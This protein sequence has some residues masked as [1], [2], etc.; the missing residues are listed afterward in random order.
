[1]PPHNEAGNH[2]HPNTQQTSQGVSGRERRILCGELFVNVCLV[3]PCFPWVYYTPFRTVCQEEKGK[4]NA[5]FC[6]VFHRLFHR[7]F[8]F[9]GVRVFSHGAGNF[10]GFFGSVRA[11]FR[12][13]AVFRIFFRPFF[14]SPVGCVVFV[15]AQ[16]P[17]CSD[18]CRRSVTPK[19]RRTSSL[20]RS[21]AASASAVAS[22]AP[23]KRI[24]QA[25]QQ[26]ASR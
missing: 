16:T 3:A 20:N 18:P 26:S 1:M 6:E 12:R 14:G 4:R 22:C 8:F 21:P 24:A 5:L 9:V 25:R 11:G 15:R 7:S 17:F 19:K 2:I 10:P 23:E 13:S